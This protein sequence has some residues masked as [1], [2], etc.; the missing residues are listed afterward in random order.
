MVITG[1]EKFAAEVPAQL[2]QKRLGVLCHAPSITS[3]FTHIIEII[4]NNDHCTPGAVFGP[5]HGLFG[6]TQD[7]MIEWEGYDDNRLKVPVFSL[8]GTNRRPTT[9]MLAHIDALV[10]D[11][12]DAGAR[13]YTYIWT[14]KH[15][16]EACSEAGIPVWI[17]D[18]PNPVGLLG[19]DGPVLRPFGLFVLR[20]SFFLEKQ[21]EFFKTNFFEFFFSR[22]K[23]D[24]LFSPRKYVIK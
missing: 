7:N 9:H 13:L 22:G 2:R 16:M 1:L 17:L 19:C 15:C 18:R 6:E 21:K 24:F 14:V 20:R 5:Q 3:D 10:V 11:I 12:Q 4:R 8:Y 23:F